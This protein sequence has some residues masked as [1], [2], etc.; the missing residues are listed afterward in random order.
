MTSFKLVM[1][2]SFRS[3][4]AP[5]K[6]FK[7]DLFNR[8]GATIER[9]GGRVIRGDFQA[10]AQLP[11]GVVPIVGCTPEL[12][13]LIDAWQARG[14]TWVYWDRGYFR[15][16]FATWLPRGENGGYYRWHVNGFQLGA[17]RDVPADR[18]AAAKTPMAPWRNAGRHIVVACPTQTYERFHQ[19]EGWTDKTLRALALVTDRQIV[20]RDKESKRPLQADLEG[21]HCLVAHASIAAVESVIMGCPVVVDRSSA[22]AL[23][24]L[25]DVSK[26]EN[27][28]MPDRDPWVRALAYS[29]F[30]ERELVDG[31]LWSLLT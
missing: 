16:V 14:R 17:V 18:W 20:V 6:K 1:T 8:I 13:P 5:L 23:V 28:V 22:A 31:T 29:Q 26:V 7:F 21:A 4:V 27:P 24:G 12:R 11:D 10:L 15:R 2:C 3:C 30:N 19:I 25:M 9:A